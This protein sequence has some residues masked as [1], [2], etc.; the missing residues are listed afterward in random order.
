VPV[1]VLGAVGVARVHVAVRPVLVGL[2]IVG[3]P[4]L[5]R[6]GHVLCA[7]CLRP[8]TGGGDRSDVHPADEQPDGQHGHQEV[9]ER[10]A[11]HAATVALVGCAAVADAA[12][13]STGGVAAVASASVRRLI[14]GV[15]P[16]LL[17]AVAAHA[18][19]GVLVH[20]G[21][22]GDPDPV[23]GV[24][25][26]TAVLAA[27]GVFLVATRRRGGGRDV[28]GWAGLLAKAVVT[29]G[30]LAA[31]T[32]AAEGYGTHLLHD[33]WILLAPAGVLV[34]HVL[35]ARLATV[36]VTSMQQTVV[37]LFLVTPVRLQVRGR[38]L[39]RL[40]VW[41]S[42]PIRGRAPPQPVLR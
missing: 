9:G 26:P 8:R 34:A 42:P 3:R 32:V 41:G 38:F 23:H 16:C 24:H 30:Y 22:F 12:V 18:A 5:W 6:V 39:D 29:T 21:P 40:S 14:T 31:E 13:S 4:A 36:M 37:R 35:S 33:P 20:A 10:S 28:D 17:G 15:V 1:C 2:R 11:D 19:T 7:W 27:V 25:A